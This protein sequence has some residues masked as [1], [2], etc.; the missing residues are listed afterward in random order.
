MKPIEQYWQDINGVSLVLYPISALL[1]GL[2]WLRR[3]CYHLGLL[4]TYSCPIPIIVVGNIYVGGNGK[5]PFVISLVHQL[6]ALGYKPAIISRG[7]GALQDEQKYGYWPRQVV[8]SNNV[9]IYGDEPYLLHQLTQCPVFI[10]PQ[11]SRAAQQVVKQTDCD[12]IISDDGLQHYALSRFIEINIVDVQRL[13]GNGLCLPAGPLR[14]KSTRLATVDYVIYNYATSTLNPVLPQDII[15]SFAMSYV[16]LDLENVNSSTMAVKTVTPKTVTPKTVMTLQQLQGKKVHAVAGIGAPQ[17][18]FDVL[19]DHKIEVIE[20][21]FA[22]HYCYNIEDLTFEQNYPIIMTEKDA[23][24]CRHF[25]L[26]NAWF[27]PIKAKI[28]KSLITKITE[29]LLTFKPHLNK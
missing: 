7:Y 25:S 3:K 23:I 24:K 5:T 26:K 21:V 18:F 22:D 9:Q 1:C 29:Q 11:R 16:L 12:V 17:R 27:L 19:R 10:D 20:H 6:K 14:E 8:T 15:N 4:K 13:H 28:D 2:A